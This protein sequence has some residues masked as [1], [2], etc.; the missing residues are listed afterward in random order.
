M[1]VQFPSPNGFA[2]S[3][4]E[5][6]RRR[7]V[8]IGAGAAGITAALHIGA[9]SVLIEQHRQAGAAGHF[10]SQ[11]GTNDCES[12]F[13]VGVA[14]AGAVC[15]QDTG[16]DRK[17]QGVSTWERQ[18]VANT[19]TPDHGAAGGEAAESGQP[20]VVPRWI[21]PRLDSADDA[22]CAA[23]VRESLQ[24]LLPL[25]RGE[26][27]LGVQVTRITP[28]AHRIDLAD[29]GAIVYDKLV[30]SVEPVVLIG[31][32]QPDLPDRIRTHQG[33][34]YWLAARDIELLDDSTQ[35]LYGDVD[36][37]SAGRRVAETVTR[38]LAQKFR[39]ASEN[40][41][42]AEKLFTPRLVRSSR[43]NAAS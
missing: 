33:L 5:P 40:F 26:V 37:F 24:S 16:A 23:G 42:C 32:L 35:F 6:E 20:V 11:G 39:P 12:R 18:A 28:A 29:G 41:L 25:L 3:G 36:S 2:A 21:P 14:R 38:A 4:L 8:I 10:Q 31:L 15:A 9:H 19:C 34:M 30:S 22:S 1:I 43:T 27:R 7:V 13:P 17:R